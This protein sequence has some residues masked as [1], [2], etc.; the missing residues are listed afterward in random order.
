MLIYQLRTADG[1]RIGSLS[2][3]GKLNTIK[4][5]AL[6]LTRQLKGLIFCRQTPDT[7]TQQ[8]TF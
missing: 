7:V 6:Y 4:L 2:S 5:E 8:S 1:F 3:F